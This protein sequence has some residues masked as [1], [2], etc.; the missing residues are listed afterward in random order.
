MHLISLKSAYFP[1]CRAIIRHTVD[2]LLLVTLLLAAV[3]ASEEDTT[4]HCKSDTK[5]YINKL[6]V[7][8]YCKTHH[9][10][11]Y[12][13]IENPDMS[14][15][16]KTLHETSKVVLHSRIARI[17]SKNVTWDEEDV[18]S[19]QKCKLTSTQYFLELDNYCIYKDFGEQ[20]EINPEATHLMRVTRLI[21][22]CPFGKLTVGQELI[23]S[24]DTES[25]DNIKD[26][27]VDIIGE[28]KIDLS[29]LYKASKAVVE[30][31]ARVCGME[32]AKVPTDALQSMAEP[33]DAHRCHR[34]AGKKS[35]QAC[36][37]ASTFVASR[38]FMTVL[39][40]VLTIFINLI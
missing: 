11:Q 24:S 19:G 20:K 31:T 25:M 26:T 36:D 23:I 40:I 5:R 13:V 3:V 8:D 12:E 4:F 15:L 35:E 18:E 1:Y 7:N 33:G 16:I 34:I 17:Y 9:K 10:N 28:I 39:V 37:A 29:H 6:E 38:T 27:S 32:N 14:H 22:R 30:Q 2:G 21:R